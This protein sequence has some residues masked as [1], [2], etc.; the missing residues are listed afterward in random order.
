MSKYDSRD[1]FD[2]RNEAKELEGIEKYNKLK[3]AFSLAIKLNSENPDDEW[4]IRAYAWV[5]IDICKYFIS[6][7]NFDGASKMFAL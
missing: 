3:E 4:I 7:D 1:I 6:N 2:L 5:A